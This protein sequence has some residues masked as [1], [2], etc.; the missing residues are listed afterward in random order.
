MCSWPDSELIDLVG[1]HCVSRKV[2]HLCTFSAKG[3]PSGSQWATEKGIQGIKR[4]NE[5]GDDSGVDLDVPG[6]ETLGYLGGLPKYNLESLASEVWLSKKIQPEPPDL[7]EDVQKA[8]QA[9]PSRS[10]TDAL[11][12]NFLGVVNYNYN[13]IYAPTF[14]EDYTAWWTARAARK[15]LSPEYTCLLLSMAH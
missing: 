3:S 1:N 4:R 8:V 10:L 11:V 2:S 6:V 15:P 14:L 12:Q 13:A 5:D 9:L 7:T